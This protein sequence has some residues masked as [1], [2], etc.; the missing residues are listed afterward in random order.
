LQIYADS[1]PEPSLWP[2]QQSC[3][4]PLDAHAP[5]HAGSHSYRTDPV[6]EDRHRKVE[7]RECILLPYHIM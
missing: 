5:K 2:P 1:E 4:C 6:G 7:R 3:S